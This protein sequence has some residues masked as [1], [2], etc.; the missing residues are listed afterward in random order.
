MNDK[1]EWVQGLHP[2]LV[3][4]FPPEVARDPATRYSI[5]TAGVPMMNTLATIAIAILIAAVVG[6]VVEKLHRPW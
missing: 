1:D 4:F 2:D 6:I 3:D 5:P